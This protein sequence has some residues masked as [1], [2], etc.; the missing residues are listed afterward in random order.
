MTTQTKPI[1]RDIRNLISGINP[2]SLPVKFAS[3]TVT[4]TVSDLHTIINS[5]TSDIKD[6]IN[7][8]QLDFESTASGTAVRIRYDGTSPSAGAGNGV[9]LAN[10]DSITLVNPEQIYKFKAIQQQA[11]THVFNIHF[12]IK[13]GLQ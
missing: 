12:F 6:R 11:G 13:T 2:E 3:L 5:L 9:P 7:S 8:A 1:S 10:G 4:G